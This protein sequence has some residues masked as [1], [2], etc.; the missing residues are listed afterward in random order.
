MFKGETMSFENRVCLSWDYHQKKKDTLAA[1]GKTLFEECVDLI[2]LDEA[3]N[4]KMSLTRDECRSMLIFFPCKM[5]FADGDINV[6]ELAF[7]NMLYPDMETVEEAKDFADN[8]GKEALELLD[9]LAEYLRRVARNIARVTAIAAAIDSSY[10]IDSIYKEVY[11]NEA[12]SKFM[13]SII[14]R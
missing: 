5:C 10:N 9:V 6:Q 13:L 1:I 11:L 2:L 3:V 12:E 7:L 8:F 4:P 14:Y